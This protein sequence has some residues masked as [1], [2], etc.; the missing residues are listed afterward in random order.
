LIAIVDLSTFRRIPWERNL[1]FFLCSFIVPETGKELD[2][3]PRGLFAQI[4]RG[5]G[6]KGLKCM[7]GAEFEVSPMDLCQILWLYNI[8]D[9]QYFQFKETP[10]TVADKG[11]TKLNPLTPG[12]T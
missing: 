4:V 8:P 6:D 1:P 3:D 10:Q 9:A 2:A 5:A 7:S 12:S 11:F